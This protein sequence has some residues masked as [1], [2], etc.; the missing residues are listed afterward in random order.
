LARA[1][2]TRYSGHFK[3]SGEKAL[4]RVRYYEA[5]NEANLS[6]YLS[7]QWDGSSY[8]G[9]GLY[10]KML[11]SFYSQIKAVN[12]SNVVISAGFAPYGD[13]HGGRRTRPLKFLRDLLCLRGRRALAPTACP[14]PAKFD[15]LG[16]HAISLSGGPAESA[17]NP[18]DVTAADLGH[19]RRVLRAAERQGTLGTGGA[20]PIWTTELWHLSPSFKQQAYWLEQALYEVWKYGSSVAMNLQVRDSAGNAYDPPGGVHQSPG[21][22][23]PNG[24]RKPSFTAF[25]FPFVVRR[26]HGRLQ[27]WLKAPRS[28][29]LTIQHKLRDRWHS[30]TS[31]RVER[32]N[33]YLGRLPRHSR[34]LFRAVVGGKKSLPWRDG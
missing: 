30:V 10:A 31:A 14:H 13:P 3:P 26:S 28:G 25:R 17:I 15:V 9:A 33:V 1:L 11:N 18:D 8:V 7:P 34:G 21:V 29:R 4:P 16:V 23:F 22:I 24:K 6:S 5:W 12:R 32:G 27:A 19:V 20:H 2:A